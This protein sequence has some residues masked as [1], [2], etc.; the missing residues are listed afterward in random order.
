MSNFREQLFQQF[1]SQGIVQSIGEFKDKFQPKKENRFN[2]DGITY[3]I[4]PVRV[5]PMG[6]EFEIS[7]KI[8]QEEIT[9]R[10][11]FEAYFAAIKE[12][13]ADD[14]RH[15]AAMDMEN[16]VH[17]VDGEEFKERD[18]VRLCYQYT[19]EEMCDNEAIGAEVARLQKDPGARPLPEVANVNT[20]TGKVV[21]LCVED[22]F[23][24]EATLRMQRLIEANQQ[25]LQTFHQQGKAV[26]A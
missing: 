20:L 15:P 11:D 1:A 6:L 5:H 19:F 24:Q 26:S 12:V 23:R 25:V 4:S 7:S 16:I 3:E 18:Y 10:N 8:P 17:D 9:D 13:L 2:V 22:F 14:S 21:L